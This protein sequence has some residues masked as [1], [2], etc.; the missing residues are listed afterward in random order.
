MDDANP[1]TGEATG[2][3]AGFRDPTELAK[4][5]RVFLYAGIAVALVYGMGRGRRPADGRR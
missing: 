3:R 1:A 2:P 4:W 5:T